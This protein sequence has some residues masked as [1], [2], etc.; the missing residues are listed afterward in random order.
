MQLRDIWDSVR[1][2][3]NVFY[4]ADGYVLLP[5]VNLNVHPHVGQ[6]N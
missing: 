1:G 2:E 3:E 4:W 5:Q 6:I